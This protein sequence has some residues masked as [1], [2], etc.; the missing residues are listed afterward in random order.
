MKRLYLLT[1]GGA[2]A[3]LANP[4][5]TLAQSSPWT[6]PC[7]AGATIDESSLSLYQT[8]AQYLT[9]A[10]SKTGTVQA[11]YDVVN[12]A[13][14]SA[15]IPTW[16]TLELDC[17]DNNAGALVTATLFQYQPCVFPRVV[18]KLCTVSSTDIG[19]QCVTCSFAPIPTDFANNVY[20]VTVNLTRNN[21]QATAPVA[22]S[23][24]VY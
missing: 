16:T 17:F 24:R 11:R 12:T 15:T 23:L 5:A 6:S 4:V 1:L 18:K 9:F 3:L 14:P 20:W 19:D 2:L 21:Q 10:S 13:D 7:S 22:Y 8:F